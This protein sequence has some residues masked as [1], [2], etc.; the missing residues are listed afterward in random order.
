MYFRFSLA[1]NQLPTFLF[2]K[3]ID[4]YLCQKF[5][6]NYSLRTLINLDQ[7]EK[8]Y[9]NFKLFIF[10]NIFQDMPSCFLEGFKTLNKNVKKINFNPKVIFSGFSHFHNERFKFW[11][12][13]ILNKKNKKLILLSHGGGYSLKFP[14]CFYF[15]NKIASQKIV[16]TKPRQ[17]NDVQ[18]TPLKFIDENKNQNCDKKYLLYLAE[19]FY[20]YPV[21]LAPG[22]QSS[23]FKNVSL[24]K[25]KIKKKIFDKF[26]YL[27]TTDINT[28]EKKRI[29]KLI[30]NKY[31]S[32]QLVFHKLKKFSKLTIC[33]GP[34]T[35]FFESIINGPTILIYDFKK[36]PII[37]DNNFDYSFLEKNLISFNNPE[38]AAKHINEIWDNIDEWWLQK[39]VKLTLDKLR[40]TFCLK[41][42]YPYNTWLKYFSKKKNEIFKN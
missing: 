38:D 15:E 12:F 35:A 2:N 41:E 39:S 24:L 5:S 30:G 17:Q 22:S 21:R 34:Q 25:K 3:K 31:H 32:K 16:W 20:D 8:T 10:E 23:N 33:T 40:D 37:S 6:Y 19:A 9:D 1:L 14:G 11:L 26:Q 13:N 42:K 29:I 28:Y 7:N 4:D 18:M 27:P 36:M